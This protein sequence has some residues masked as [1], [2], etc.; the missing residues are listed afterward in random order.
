M[1]RSALPPRS[2]NG[3]HNG[4]RTLKKHGKTAENLGFC[5]TNTW[6]NWEVFGGKSV[7]TMENNEKSWLSEVMGVPLCIIQVMDD[8]DLVLKL[9]TSGFPISR[10]TH[11][12]K[13]MNIKV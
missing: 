6:E 2:D 8:H 4:E 5:W 13:L 1:R 9:A 12:G 10:I 7:V 11:I 3:P